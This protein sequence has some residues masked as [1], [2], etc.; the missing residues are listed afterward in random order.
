[1]AQVTFGS[2]SFHQLF[3]D[4]EINLFGYL[5]S[6]KYRY[7]LNTA[8]IWS[9]MVPTREAAFVDRVA[10]R[11]RREGLRVANIAVD[12]ARVW[13]DDPDARAHQRAVAL[14]YLTRIGPA[15]GAQTIRIDMGPRT[16]HLTPEMFDTVVRAYQEYARLAG[17]RGIRIGPQNHYGATTVVSEFQSVYDAVNHPA[18]GLVLDVGRWPDPVGDEDA[19]VASTVIHTHFD[20]LSTGEILRDKVR[21]LLAAGYRGAWSY[22]HRSG[23]REYEAVAAAVTR[24]SEALAEAEDDACLKERR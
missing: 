21:I 10:A 24:L 20:A 3:A 14:D 6:L 13:D 7:H 8:D 23:R 4:G 17:D 16:P 9:G 11:L 22:E 2:W 19:A 15:W 18:F 5:Q 1:M 12:E